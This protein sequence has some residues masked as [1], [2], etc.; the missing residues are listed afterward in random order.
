MREI[1][2]MWQVGVLAGKRYTF[3]GQ[4]WVTFGVL[5]LQKIMRGF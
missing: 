3:W 2:T 4:E 5:A 1:G